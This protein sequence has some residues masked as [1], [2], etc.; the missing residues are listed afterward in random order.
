MK[1]PFEV[2]I[3]LTVVAMVVSTASRYRSDKKDQDIVATEDLKLS[4]TDPKIGYSLTFN[5]LRPGMTVVEAEKIF[6][7]PDYTKKERRYQQ[8]ERPLTQVYFSEEGVLTEVGGSGR[9]VL[10]L[11]K[12]EVFRCGQREGDI[13]K[14][15]GQPLSVNDME[16]NYPGM[17]LFCGSA[18][19]DKRWVSAITLGSH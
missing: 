8:W 19:G 3:L 10:Y 9:G 7:P 14:T 15:F 2:L 16:Y 17:S 13:I 6:G 11:G 1:R 18:E 12:D 5:K 4:L